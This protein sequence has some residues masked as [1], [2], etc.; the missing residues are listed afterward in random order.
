MVEA[1]CEC[2]AV[3]VEVETP[4]ETV[5]D[6]NCS[7]CRRYGALWAYYPVTSV[8]VTGATTIYLRG[9]RQL[10]FHHCAVCRCLTHWS[11]VDKSY[12]RMGVNARLMRPEVLKRAKVVP[13]DGAS[14]PPT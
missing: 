13:L 4:P 2:G 14:G 7:I 8:R 10:E 9:D 3:R 1:S 5:G 12:N 11:P 6:C